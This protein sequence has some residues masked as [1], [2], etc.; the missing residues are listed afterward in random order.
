MATVTPPREAAV[1]APVV[2]PLV[3]ADIAVHLTDAG[4]PLLVG[5]TMPLSSVRSV[6]NKYYTHKLARR[7]TLPTFLECLGLVFVP[8]NEI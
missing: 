4:P 3:A 1:R 5:L 2:L 7:P 6:L 8:K